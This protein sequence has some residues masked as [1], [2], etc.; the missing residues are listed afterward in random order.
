[1]VVQ[2]LMLVLISAPM[3]T[4][5][6]MLIWFLAISFT[7]RPHFLW[8][9]LFSIFSFRLNKFTSPRLLYHPAFLVVLS[10]SISDRESSVLGAYRNA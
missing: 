5:T 7:E 6:A 4:V 8:M 2:A 9:R 3:I 1:M 10:L